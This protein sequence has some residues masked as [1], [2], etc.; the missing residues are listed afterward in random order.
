MFIHFGQL[1]GYVLPLAGLVLP[2][3]LWQVKKAELPGLDVHGKIVCNWI[4]SELIYGVIGGVLCLACG[5]GLLILIPLAIIGVIFPIIGGIKASSG[6]VWRYPQL[7]VL[8]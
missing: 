7:Q 3:I 8:K 4:I 6:E 2:F 5:I 1:A